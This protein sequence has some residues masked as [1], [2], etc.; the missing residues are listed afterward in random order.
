MTLQLTYGGYV[1][2]RV[3]DLYN[4]DV[5]PSGID[6]HFI[7]A[8]VEHIFHRMTFNKEFDASEMSFSTYIARVARNE[9]PFIAIPVFPSRMFRHSS[10]YINKRSGIK[11]PKDLAG[12]RVG[13]PEYQMTAA[14]WARGILLNEYGVKPEEIAEW[15]TGGLHMPGRRQMVS[16]D[17]PNVK[18][19]R[20]TTKTLNDM[21]AAGEL[22]ALV[23]AREP[24][25][26]E[27]G[28]PDIDRMFPN[29]DEVEM[30]YYNKTKMFPLMHTVVIRKDFY[31]KYPWAAVSLYEAFEQAKDN[32][33]ERMVVHGLSE[34]PISL[35]WIAKEISK[36]RNLMGEDFWPYGLEK[37][38]KELDAMCQ[39]S[40]EQ[41]ISPRRVNPEE[42]FAPNVLS[43]ALTSKI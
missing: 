42:L 32:C 5:K 10:I 40:Y 7:N 41:G 14:L 2:D 12:K 23:S 36:T 26:L 13:V 17:I 33:L 21:L 16:T 20:E 4:G 27:I 31:E 8:D 9:S 34:L 37:N 1:T 38:F 25:A 39:Y 18:I 19:T 22:D 43:M 24:H 35:P 28:H 30:A 15:V 6:L 3:V 11:E 29:Y